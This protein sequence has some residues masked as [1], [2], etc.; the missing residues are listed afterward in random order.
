MQA[1]LIDIFDSSNAA[2]ELINIGVSN[3]GRMIMGD[4][5]KFIVIKLKNINSTALNILKQEA[6]SIGAELANHKDV[7]TGKI[8]ESD[9]ILFGTPVQLRIIVKKIKTQEFGLKELSKDLESILAAIGNK[10]PKI[11]K[12]N[13]GDI[14]FNGKTYIM[15]ILNVTPDSFSDGGDYFDKD[16]AIKRGFE[17]E[18]EGAD[19]IDI[20]GESTRPGSLK[21]DEQVEIDRVCPVI[22]KLSKTINL[23]IS[24]DTRKPGV[25][26]E[27]LKT[28]ASI[29]NDVSGLGYDKERMAGVLAATG[30]PYILMHSRGKSPEDMQRD[31][32][33]YDDIF[34][35]ILTYFNEKIEYLEERGYGRNNIIIDPGFGFAKSIDDNYNIL[36]DITSFKSLGL[37][38]LCGVSRKS[39]INA[40]TGKNRNDVLSGNVAVASYM[41]LKKVDIVRV[42]DVKQTALAFAALDKITELS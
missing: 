29:I 10:D 1:Y 42:H 39:F 34:Y 4:K 7:I 3:S 35:D 15:G 25:A 31:L 41:K 32:K 12:T 5:L 13:K 33:A 28:G 23:P 24:I 8:A 2:Q 30:A 18:R 22:E 38:L 16:A 11:L 9:S 40:V 19:I 17:L 14:V 26:A 27:A 21:V 20:G 36:S 6:L 37:P